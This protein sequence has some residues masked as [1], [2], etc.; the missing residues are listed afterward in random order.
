MSGVS[1]VNPIHLQDVSHYL[2]TQTPSNH[3]AISSSEEVPPEGAVSALERWNQSNT[4]IFKTISTF[5]GFVV[6]GAN[7]AAY[8]ALIPYLGTYYQVSYTVV[9]LVFLSPFVGYVAAAALNNTLHKVVGQ[10]GVAI[11]GPGS[12]LLAYVVIS[13]HPPY[14]VLVFVFILAGFGNGILDAAWNAWIGNLANPNEIL[15]FLHGFYGVGATVSPLIAT[16]M[17][18]KQGLQWYAF[19]YVMVIVSP[20]TCIG[21]R[22]IMK[23]R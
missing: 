21:S 11:L 1:Q 17:I 15:G 5:F 23:Y 20:P 9:S 12:H 19:Y 10:R 6:M 16:M 7:D 13:L 8:G 18:T 14:P 4:N 3:S 2:G 22:L